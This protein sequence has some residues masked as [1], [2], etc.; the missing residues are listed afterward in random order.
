MKMLEID[1]LIMKIDTNKREQTNKG[2]FISPYL[3][4][5]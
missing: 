5:F 1:N 2:H 4:V 3:F